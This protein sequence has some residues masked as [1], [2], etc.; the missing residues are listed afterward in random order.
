MSVCIVP[1]PAVHWG[2]RAETSNGTHVFHISTNHE[3]LKKQTCMIFK[4]L[5]H[6]QKIL[7]VTHYMQSYALYV[8]LRTLH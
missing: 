4:I 1:L 8:I 2:R 3:E 7:I 5:D 6:M